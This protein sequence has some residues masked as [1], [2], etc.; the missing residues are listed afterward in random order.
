MDDEHP[1]RLVVAHHLGD[2]FVAAVDEEVDGLSFVRLPA[3][4]EPWP[5]ELIADVLL[6]TTRGTPHLPAAVAHG[7]EWVHT[8]GT[9]VDGFPLDQVPDGVVLTCSRGATAVPIA[10][11]VLASMLALVKDLPDIW[12]DEP[13]A[14]WHWRELGGLAGEQVTIVGMGTIGTEVARRCLAFDMRVVG[15]RRRGLDAPLPGITMVVDPVEAVVDARHVVVAAP[16]TPATHHLV[17]ERLLGA[18]RAGFHLVNIARGS[19]VDQDA[20]R[21]ALDGGQVGRATL[22]TVDPEPLPAGHWLYEHPR[23][24]LTPHISWS[25]PL[26]LGAFHRPFVDNLR[27]RLAGKPLAGVVDRQAGY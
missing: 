15:V 6:T 18:A 13:P 27:R 25:S 14:S 2:D 16:A 3:Q 10:E 8:V 23:V 21:R 19:L 26:S 24:R 7:V 9:G 17:D 12:L 5:D 20:L 4:D 22:D 11:Y 1:T